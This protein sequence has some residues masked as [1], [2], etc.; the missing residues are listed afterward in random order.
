M[1]VSRLRC[2]TMLDTYRYRE[3]RMRDC[4]S[5]PLAERAKP[6]QGAVDKSRY[7][8]PRRGV[9]PPSGEIDVSIAALFRGTAAHRHRPSSHHIDPVKPMDCDVAA[10]EDGYDPI[11]P[12]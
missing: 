8:T 6:L 11:F 10:R 9:S 3:R 1:K 5:Q 4:S 7:S 12:G 2:L